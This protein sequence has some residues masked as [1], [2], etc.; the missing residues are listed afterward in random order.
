MTYPFLHDYILSQEYIATLKPKELGKLRHN[1]HPLQEEVINEALTAF[2]PFPIELKNFYRE[3]GFGYFH[4]DKERVN[5]ILDPY[6]LIQMNNLEDRFLY[7]V[8][9]KRAFVDGQL[10]FFQT[11]L[12]Q[13]LTIDRKAINGENAI[14]YKNHKIADSLSELL[15]YYAKDRDYL[16]YEIKNIDKDEIKKGIPQATLRN[17]FVYQSEK[18][19][20]E[21]PATMIPEKKEIATPVITQAESPQK[22]KWTILFEDDDIIEIK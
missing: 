5:R 7:D 14:S 3:I 8:E 2:D 12:Y 13:F 4:C 10:V 19:K 15:T 20:K 22:S 1:F 11:Y 16:Q 21:K 17:T 9:L 18:E 6:S